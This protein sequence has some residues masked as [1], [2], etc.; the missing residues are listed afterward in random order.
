MSPDTPSE[1]IVAR[2]Y[3]SSRRLTDSQIIII[4][5]LN[6]VIAFFTR[7]IESG[8]GYST[9]YLTRFPML[10]RL[11]ANLR[12]SACEQTCR[13]PRESCVRAL[14]TNRGL[15]HNIHTPSCRP[16]WETI[17]RLCCRTSRVCR[18][19]RNRWNQGVAA[20]TT[21]FSYDVAQ[22]TGLFRGHFDSL[23]YFG[24]GKD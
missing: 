3:E 21:G 19:H 18:K 17:L 4:G 13:N 6:E 23:R 1:L 14:S 9:S 24:S 11:M 15:E 22:M 12:T 8:E 16:H 5:R 7:F 10:R 2:F 20:L